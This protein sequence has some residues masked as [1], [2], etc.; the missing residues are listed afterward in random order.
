MEFR[1]FFRKSRIHAA[2][3]F[4]VSGE[5]IVSL[6][7]VQLHEVLPEC[8]RDELFLLVSEDSK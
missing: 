2:K 8:V 1:A 3:V 7:K 6:F 5:Q 4:I